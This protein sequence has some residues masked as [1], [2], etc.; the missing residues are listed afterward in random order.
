M[1]SLTRSILTA[2]AIAVTAAPAPAFAQRADMY[3]GLDKYIESAMKDWK[4]PGVAVG[5]VRNDSVV[6]AKGFGVRAVGRPEKVDTHTL[7]A[8]A[9]DTK[10]FTGIL[11]AMLADEGK[12]RWDAPLTTYLPT[13][14]FGD[15]FLTRELTVRDALTHRSGLARADLLWTAG[16]T[17]DRAELLR[18]L[19][20]LKPSWN[21]RTRYGYSNLMYLAA[22]EAAAAATGKS[23][24]TL[25]R[26]RIFT[27]L[28]MTETNT[29]VTLL[30]SL[31]NVASP[32]AFADSAV[33]VVSY[34]N[35]DAAASAGAINSNI[36]DMTRWVRFQLD[37]GRVN[38]K[39]LVSKRNFIETHMPQTVI[40]VDS[41]YRAFNPFTHLKSYAFGWQVMDFRGRE[42]LSHAGNLSGMNAMV[43]LMPEERIGVVVLTNLE[44]NALRESIMYKVFD[45]SLGARPRDW[46]RISLVEKASFDAIEEK[47]R[48]E[49]EAKRVKGTRPSLPLE[50]Y[51][52]TYQDSLYGKMIVRMEN[53]HLVLDIAPKMIG[54]MEHWHYDTFRV[55]WRD[56]RDGTNLVTFALD[57]D[58]KVDTMSTDIGGPPEETPRMKRMSDSIERTS[59][60]TK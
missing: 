43:G 56:H 35:I 49:S 7:F 36:S 13:L 28:G 2:A 48:R 42:I 20:Y 50:R 29:S 4:I 46:S 23:W 39:R 44:G 45:M 33:R 26:E 59:S 10:A 58:G 32:H 41:T 6:F 11:L 5:I 30:P 22:G 19:R 21:L 17:Y 37:S 8:I 51:A 1:K 57:M 34:T 24:D 31:A 60:G 40:R 55:V 15:D 16:W 54:D 38:G 3:V 12:I 52:G 18:R 27:P 14:K 25:V 9:S 53:G 47:D